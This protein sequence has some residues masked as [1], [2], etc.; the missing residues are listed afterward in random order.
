M[1][2]K[3]NNE[4]CPNTLFSNGNISIGEF[5]T[6]EEAMNFPIKEIWCINRTND[7]K[8][9]DHQ[10]RGVRILIICDWTK[11]TQD[12]QKFVVALVPKS[13]KISYLDMND[14][15]III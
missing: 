1:V 9:N 10:S 8:F 7:N 4:W 12:S 6:F 14:L 3:Y 2:K 11:P 13:G 5:K 15:P